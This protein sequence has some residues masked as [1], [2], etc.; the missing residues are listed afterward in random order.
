M[1]AEE[2]WGLP[3]GEPPRGE[4]ISLPF[5]E[6]AFKIK[7][8]KFTSQPFIISDFW[9]TGSSVVQ[10]GTKGPM[11]AGNKVDFFT[12]KNKKMFN[13]VPTGENINLDP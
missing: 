5:S 8:W 1:K 11:S 9:E 2:A 7:K 6:F 4:T 13:K 10:K 3:E 12:I